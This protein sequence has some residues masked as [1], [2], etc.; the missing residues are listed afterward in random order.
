MEKTRRK[1]R[2]SERYTFYTEDG[3]EQMASDT[4]MPVSKLRWAVMGG[5]RR[6]QQLHLTMDERRIPR[7]L[8]VPD[9]EVMDGRV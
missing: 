5:G 4:L 6:L 2:V 9:M 7:W 8:D 1:R 3:L